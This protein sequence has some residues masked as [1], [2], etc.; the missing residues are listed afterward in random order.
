MNDTE[1]EI[2]LESVHEENKDEINDLNLKYEREWK[3]VNDLYGEF[4]TNLGVDLN[5]LNLQINKGELFS[6][7]V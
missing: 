5:N 7:L 2:D 1:L 3:K 6:L 4:L